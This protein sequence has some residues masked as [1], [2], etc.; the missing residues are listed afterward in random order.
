MAI[1]QIRPLAWEPLYATGA[2]IEKPKKKLS[3]HIPIFI[4]KEKKN[5][6]LEVTSIIYF[7][8]FFPLSM[9]LLS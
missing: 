1:A 6:D 4:Y 2:A 5:P 3:V 9:F 8:Y 7:L